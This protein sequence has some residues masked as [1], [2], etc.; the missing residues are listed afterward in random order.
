M[1]PWLGWTLLTS[2]TL[3]AILIP[4]AIYE[5]PITAWTE[6]FVADPGA[7]ATAA[8]VL[9][10]L[11]AAD[12][13]LPVPSSLVSTACGFVLG[14]GLGVAVSW[15]GMTFGAL[16][17]YWLG[18]RPARA[19]TRRFVGDR[20]M[21][22]AA[23]A[24]RRWGD[25]A[26]VVCR[27]VPV[28]AEASVVFAGVN[29]MPLGRFLFTAGLANLGVSLVYGLVG[30]WALEAGSFLLAFAAAVALPGLA[31]LAARASGGPGRPS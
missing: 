26:V 17:G 21:A 29:G 11:L 22:K 2:L 18:R 12:V 10:G 6:D 27:S 20:E 24:W 25:W 3:A 23:E 9:G 30:A 31:M 4:F 13:L 16:I 7:R 19:L 14:A 1:K 15:L 28:L 5:Q 8:A